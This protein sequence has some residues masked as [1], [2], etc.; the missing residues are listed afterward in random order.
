MT[1][2]ENLLDEFILQEKESFHVEALQLI[3][4]PAGRNILNRGLCD[5][6]GAWHA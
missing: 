5:R 6:S 1:R 2:G 3:K 4:N